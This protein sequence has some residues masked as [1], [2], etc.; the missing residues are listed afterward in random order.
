ML[1]RTQ[2][3]GGSW[4]GGGFMGEQTCIAYWPTLPAPPRIRIHSSLGSGNAFESGSGIRSPL[5]SP[6]DA[7][8]F[9]SP[10]PPSQVIINL[11]GSPDFFFF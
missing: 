3:E 7:V 8:Y 1:R 5:K 4:G 2:N 6:R 9:F 11:N 10:P